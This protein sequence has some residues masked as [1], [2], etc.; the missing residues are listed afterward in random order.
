MR[1]ASAEPEWEG[2]SLRLVRV[3]NPDARL[4]ASL[5]AYD[6]QAFGSLGL[7]R[8]DLAVMAKTGWVLLAYLRDEI[9]GGCQLIRMSDEP[10]MFYV[11]GIYV[12]PKWRG[13]GLGHAFLLAVAEDA[14][15]GGAAGLVLTV[16]PDNVKAMALYRSVGFVEEESVPDFYGDG[17]DRQV[18]RW[19]FSE[20]DLTGSV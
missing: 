20:R 19:R 13:R 16:S 9:V 4:L 15:S 5:E 1:P 17:E 12:L 14:R 3:S 7:R 2:K 10:D 18:L 8:C 11:V 6:R